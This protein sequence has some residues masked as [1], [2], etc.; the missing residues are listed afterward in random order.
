MQNGQRL[1]KSGKLGEVRL[2]LLGFVTPGTT[3]R[4]RTVWKMF[5]CI[6]ELYTS[7]TLQTVFL[8]FLNG[9]FIPAAALT[10]FC[11]AYEKYCAGLKILLQA[12]GE[13][14]SFEVWVRQGQSNIQM[15][16]LFGQVM[17]QLREA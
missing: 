10:F 15:I 13:L 6:F 9:L 5:L 4:I 12:R 14:L 11:Q 2:S 7:K 1:A 3:G 17:P 8:F 16:I